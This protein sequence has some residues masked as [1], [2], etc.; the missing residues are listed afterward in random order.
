MCE[1]I[2]VRPVG[3]VRA[4]ADEQVMVIEVI[5]ELARGLE[6][7]ETQ[8]HL[9]VLY[10]MHGLPPKERR[11]LRVHPRGDRTQPKRGVF[12]LHSPCRPNPIGMTRVRLIRREEN[13][14]LV[15]QLDA[16]DGSPVLDIKSG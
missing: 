15:E 9:W 11:R 8:D 16:L 10:W 6:G 5:P 14:L 12:A 3:F 4:T 2:S 13:R 1:A 7:I